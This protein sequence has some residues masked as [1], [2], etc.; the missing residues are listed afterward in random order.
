MLLLMLL[1]FPLMSTLACHKS[2]YTSTTGQ[3][4]PVPWPVTGQDLH[5]AQ[6]R[7]YLCRSEFGTRFS[8]TAT[9]QDIQGVA[10][11]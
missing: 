10:L 4:L 5:L 8:R 6:V 9:G 3:D 11:N 7:I 2:G 1:R